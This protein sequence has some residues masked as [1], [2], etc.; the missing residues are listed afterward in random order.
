MGR[1]ET[2][3]GGEKLDVTQLKRWR[4]KCDMLRVATY[5]RVQVQHLTCFQCP[6]TQAIHHY[7]ALLSVSR[8]RRAFTVGRVCYYQLRHETE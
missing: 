2:E 5:Y 6:Q 3:D 7:F 4:L 8:R 1:T